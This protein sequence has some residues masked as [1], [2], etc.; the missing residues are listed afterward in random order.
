MY[1]LLKNVHVGL[2]MLSIG[3]FLLRAYWMTRNSRMLDR[4]IV[5]I[6]PHAIDTAFLLSGIALVLLL[7]LRVTQSPWLLAKLL[8]LVAYIV[9]GTIALKRGRTLRIRLAALLL[10]VLTFAYIV[11]AAVNKSPGSWLGV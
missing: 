9:C 6:L 11:G 8:A 7:Q 1:L 5:R 10:A 4:R 2:A 3:G